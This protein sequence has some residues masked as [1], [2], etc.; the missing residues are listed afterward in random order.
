MRD[1][2]SNQEVTE[3]IVNTRS[4]GPAQNGSGSN[5]KAAVPYKIHHAEPAAWPT[6]TSQK[7]RFA[8]SIASQQPIP[9][10]YRSPKRLFASLI[11]MPASC[12]HSP[13]YWHSPW[14]EIRI[15]PSA[16]RWSAPKCCKQS[17]VVLRSQ[18]FI[19][20]ER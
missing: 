10:N 19:W 20:L 17:L 1:R 9:S 18:F 13:T 5:A 16:F 6:S 8:G 7:G 12:C 15:T 2:L 11:A 14:P 3:L 4:L